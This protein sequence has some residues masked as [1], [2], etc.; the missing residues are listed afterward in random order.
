MTVP[1]S[2]ISL[3]EFAKAMRETGGTFAQ[4]V[5]GFESRFGAVDDDKLAVLAQAS[6]LC[7]V[8]LEAQRNLIAV[9]EAIRTG[10][11]THQYYHCQITPER[12]VEMHSYLVGIQRWLGVEQPLP[13][14]I[15]ASKVEQI[16]GWL[17][18]PSPAKIALAELFLIRLVD[19]LLN[20]VSL[21]ALG[22]IPAVSKGEYPDFSAWYS[23]GDGVPYAIART[24][25]SSRRPFA[26]PPFKTRADQL[27]AI[28]RRHMP[29]RPDDASEL[30]DWITRQTQPP[31]MHRFSRYLD[32]QIASIGA[33][34]LRGNPPPDRIPRSEWQSWHDQARAA[35]RAWA[36]GAR[37]DDERARHIHATLGEPTEPKRA[38]VR[39]FLLGG[40]HD[41]GDTA[42]WDWLVIGAQTEGTN[43]CGQFRLLG[44][45]DSAPLH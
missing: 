23:S 8:N 1:G 18:E 43:A 40:F 45:F 28:V 32:L 25:D 38:I 34:K 9:C 11:P 6:F 35:L 20:Y 33:L 14:Q 41:I 5:S 4:S 31:C 24:G 13:P 17:G 12:W 37:P 7:W 30:I 44:L 16:A 27:C 29:S 2:T 39:D 15:D 36:E 21:A 42:G 26:S 22:S 19:D 3:T 10:K